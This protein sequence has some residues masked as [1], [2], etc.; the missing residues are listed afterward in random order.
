MTDRA[1]PTLHQIAK[2]IGEK[3]N[4]VLFDG[5]P[6]LEVPSLLD[7]AD[8]IL[9]ASPTSPVEPRPQPDA[10]A[11]RNAALE[12]ALAVAEYTKVK[13]DGRKRGSLT[14]Q[15]VCDAIAAGIRSLTI[16]ADKKECG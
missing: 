8:A 15:M 5:S 10:A 16:T 6:A 4:P 12:E 14:A 2:I 13:T 3:V 9:A 1:M 11:I 7:A